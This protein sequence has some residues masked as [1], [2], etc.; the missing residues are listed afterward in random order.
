MCPWPLG[1]PGLQVLNTNLDFSQIVLQVSIGLQ[2][3]RIL[4]NHREVHFM[5]VCK[6]CV[7]KMLEVV[8]LLF[9][10]RLLFI[11]L[12]HPNIPIE[13]DSQVG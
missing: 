11:C 3:F 1:L 2:A 5:K 7:N 13:P 4:V 6:S 10:A 12:A 8:K 9:R